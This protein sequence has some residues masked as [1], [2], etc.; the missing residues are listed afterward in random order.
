MKLVPVISD[1][2][3]KA[4]KV[5]SLGLSNWLQAF[6]KCYGMLTFFSKYWNTSNST[7]RNDAE[8]KAVCVNSARDT[9]G[10][11]REMDKTHK[12]PLQTARKTFRVLKKIL[13]LCWSFTKHFCKTQS[14]EKR[15]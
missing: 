4:A 8:S 11:S 15:S 7:N 3:R 14:L 1:S 2:N 13:N 9:L 12:N 10:L 6:Q 5:S